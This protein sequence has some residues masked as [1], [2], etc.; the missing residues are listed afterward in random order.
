M[1]NPISSEAK[2]GIDVPSLPSRIVTARNSG[3]TIFVT[4]G[5][6]R[7]IPIRFSPPLASLP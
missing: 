6:L 2:D 7:L 3:S 4:A 1:F 5:F